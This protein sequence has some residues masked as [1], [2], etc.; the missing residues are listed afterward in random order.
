MRK[1]LI[2]TVPEKDSKDEQS[3]YS[4]ERSVDI[5]QTSPKNP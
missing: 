5:S 4:P 2:E 3:S 1:E